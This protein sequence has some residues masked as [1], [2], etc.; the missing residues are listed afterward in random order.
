MK[1]NQIIISRKCMSSCQ[2]TEELKFVGLKCF[3]LKAS[4]QPEIYKTN[5]DSLLENWEK[6]AAKHST[7]K[8]ILLNFVNLSTTFC[9]RLSEKKDFYFWFDP[10]HVEFI[11]FGDFCIL[12][13]SLP[14]KL[15]FRATE[16]RQ[17]RNSLGTHAVISELVGIE[18]LFIRND[19]FSIKF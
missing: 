12:N 1:R 6:S 3:A 16:L 15:I 19:R 4:T 8:T 7:E 10:G 9:P 5:F 18:C 2:T 14:L 13:D 17:R 11:S